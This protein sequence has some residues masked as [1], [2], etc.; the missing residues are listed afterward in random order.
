MFHNQAVGERSF[1][2]TNDGASFEWPIL[3]R[4]DG[5]I[6]V[7]IPIMNPGFLYDGNLAGEPVFFVADGSGGVAVLGG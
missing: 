7:N 6:V 3:E 5:S 2:S 4:A 1:I